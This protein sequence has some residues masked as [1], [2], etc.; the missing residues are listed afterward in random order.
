MAVCSVIQHN[1]QVNKIRSVENF[2]NKKLIFV[3]AFAFFATCACTAQQI[4]RFGVVD[5]SRVYNA[6]FRN[7]SAVRNYESRRAEYQQEIQNL[8]DEIRSLE[9]QRLEYQKNEDSAS[10]MRLEGEITRRTDFLREYTNAKNVELE[11]ML[12]SLKTSD[13]FYQRLYSVLS[14]IAET[15]GYSMILSLQQSNGILWYSNSVD[16]TDQVISQLGL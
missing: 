15:G 9:S 1:Q 3:C 13:E 8:T 2:M 5:T 12:R 7:S 4:T 10:V 16:V 11:S 6:Y 14:R